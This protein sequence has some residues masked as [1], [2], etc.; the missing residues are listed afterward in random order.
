[1]KKDNSPFID[2]VIWVDLN[3]A[4]LSSAIKKINNKRKMCQNET[5]E[6]ALFKALRYKKII[7]FNCEMTSSESD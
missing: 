7:V 2:G 6:E 4:G 3:S 1:M 5:S